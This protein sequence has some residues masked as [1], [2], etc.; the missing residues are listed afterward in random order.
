[1]SSILF[2]FFAAPMLERLSKFTS[3]NNRNEVAA[4]VDDTYCLAVSKSHEINCK[5]LENMHRT[6]VEWTDESDAEFEP[7]KYT[8]MHFQRPHTRKMVNA[9]IP[10]IPGMDKK[11]CLTDF[12]R[13]LGVMVHCRLT[14]YDHVLNVSD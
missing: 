12:K 8:V 11:K 10:D 4:Y 3:L 2:L 5:I 7:S 6:I 1:M 14:W 13:I 9:P